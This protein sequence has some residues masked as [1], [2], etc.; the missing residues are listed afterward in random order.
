MSRP[1]DEPLMTFLPARSQMYAWWEWPD[2]T[3]SLCEDMSVTSSTNGPG[4]RPPLHSLIEPVGSTW[5]EPWWTTT[6]WDFT[7]NRASSL[8]HLL[9]S[10]DSSTKSTSATPDG[11]TI[12][13]VSSRSAPMKAIGWPLTRLITNGGSTSRCVPL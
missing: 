7:P 3:T 5:D 4:A 8:D 10:V 1:N 2:M 12:V 6:T 11:S 13:G 9:I